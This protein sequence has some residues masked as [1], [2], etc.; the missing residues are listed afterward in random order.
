MEPIWAQ[1]SSTLPDL[2]PTRASTEPFERRAHQRICEAL[3]PKR[4]QHGRLVKKVYFP[5]ESPGHKVCL[6]MRSGWS[7]RIG[8]E[9]ARERN[10]AARPVKRATSRGAVIATSKAGRP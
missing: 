4:L 5:H 2:R 8:A 10:A 3:L 1:R 7:H 9:A 6:T